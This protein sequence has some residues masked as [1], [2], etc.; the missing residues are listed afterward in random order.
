MA[1][2]IAGRVHY[3]GERKDIRAGNAGVPYCISGGDMP[4]YADDRVQAEL[5]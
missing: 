5:Q 3:E 1:D 2:Q 4:V